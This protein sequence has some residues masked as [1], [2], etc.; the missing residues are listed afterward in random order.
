MERLYK[1]TDRWLAALDG[2]WTVDEETGEVF[3]PADIDEIEASLDEKVENIACYLKD[4]KAYAEAIKA[5]EESLKER[6]QTIERKHDR[7]AAYLTD[8]L[9]RSGKR[10][11]ETTRADVSLRR[12]KSV[13]IEDEGAIPDKYIRT[14]VRTAPDKRAISNDL[15]SGVEV[16]GCSLAERDSLQVR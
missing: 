3:D 2:A 1:L 13:Q 6:R 12:V 10:R 4:L 8:Q 9:T 16:P 15:K 11:V 5:E 14:T 7:L